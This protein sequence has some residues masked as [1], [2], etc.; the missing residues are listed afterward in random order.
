[1]RRIKITAHISLDG[2]IQHSADGTAFPHSDWTL[3]Y[4]TPEEG[5]A[6]LAAYGERFDLVLGRRTDDAWSGFW[7]TALASPMGDRI[8]AATKFVDT[9]RPDSLHWGPSEAIGPDLI[10]AVRRLDAQGDR[11]CCC[12]AAPR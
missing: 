9:H 5:D 11:T 4:R 2:V 7:P 10:D 8:N 12:P 3:P 6:L 1:M